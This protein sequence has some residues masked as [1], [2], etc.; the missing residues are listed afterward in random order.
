MKKP[1]GGSGRL[2]RSSVRRA[3]AKG[4]AI[5]RARRLR[6]RLGVKVIVLL[7]LH[8]RANIFRRHQADL[9]PLSHKYPAQ[10]MRAAARLHRHD[11][12]LK[13]LD[14]VLQHVPSHPASQ[15]HPARGVQP[16]HA[17]RVLAK[18]DPNN[19]DVHRPVPLSLK[20]TTT[21]ADRG[22]RGGPSHNHKR[23]PRLK[24][25]PERL[26]GRHEIATVQTTAIDNDAG[27]V[28]L[29]TV[30]AHSSG[31]WISSEWP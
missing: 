31:E 25:F 7:R 6:N 17:A 22:E 10:M 9:V 4:P 30:L 19:D 15:D 12:T 11:A 21:L 16:R 8:I 14:E 3:G 26:S 20:P 24:F 2:P 13:T 28:R 27:L 29:T 5:A 23:F 1:S 18:I